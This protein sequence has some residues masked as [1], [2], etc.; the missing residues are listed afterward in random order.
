MSYDICGRCHSR[1]KNEFMGGTHGELVDGV[2]Y[3]WNCARAI[4][5]DNRRRD[6]EKARER[7]RDRERERREYERQ[8][9]FEE[10]RR[11]DEEQHHREL[12]EQQERHHQEMLDATLPWYP[13]SNCGT[14]TRKD[15][16]WDFDGGKICTDCWL[17]VTECEVCH[18]KYVMDKRKVRYSKDEGFTKKKREV[19]YQELV[20]RDNTPHAGK[21]S[22][23]QYD[24]IQRNLLYMCPSC[25]KN[26][27]INEK[28]LWE[29][30]HKLKAEYD[31][32]K[33]T[34]EKEDKDAED[35][36][37][38][39]KRIAECEAK[40]K[41]EKERKTV[42][43]GCLGVIVLVTLLLLAYFKDGNM[44]AATVIGVVALTLSIIFKS[45]TSHLLFGLIFGLIFTL[46]LG[47]IIS[48]IIWF[49]KG[50]FLIP[51]AVCL[52]ISIVLGT[53]L[54]AVGVLENMKGRG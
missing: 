15:K 13:C 38:R 20:W 34:K 30:S 4:R 43:G 35:K 2:W 44:V 49:V 50:I 36:A 37:A 7:E 12:M 19:E 48:G 29:T 40:E 8:E 54:D 28:D 32:L 6:E 47:T 45:F 3:C 22:I 23:Q 53:I 21:V 31:R 51:L 26:S 14:D 5:N 52:V 18:K 27:R 39:E 42:F 17:K 1:F 41:E 11:L 16:L 46:I 10:Q 9:A 24:D 33:A 25:Y